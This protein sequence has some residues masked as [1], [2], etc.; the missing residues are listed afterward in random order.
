MATDRSGNPL[1]FCITTEALPDIPPMT[2]SEVAGTVSKA[3]DRYYKANTCYGCTDPGSKNFDFQ[4]NVDDDS[5]GEKSVNNFTFGGVFQTCQVDPDHSQ[6]NLCTSITQINPLTGGYSCPAGYTEVKLRSGT[7]SHVSYGTVCNQVC[8]HCG[9]FGWSKCCSCQ[10]VNVA[11]M[12]MARYKTFWC[13]ALSAVQSR[14]Y[15]FGGVFTSASANPVTDAA[16]CPN[17]F[18]PLVMGQDVTVC[19]STDYELGYAYSLRFAGFDSCEVGNPFAA[20]VSARGDPAKW[21]NQCIRGYSQHLVTIDDG[22]EINYCLQSG[23]LNGRSLMPIRL[24]PFSPPPQSKM[25]VTE[26]SVVGGVGGEVWLRGEGNTW[27]KQRVGATDGRSLLNLLETSG[28][29]SSR[30][31]GAK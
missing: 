28:N 3:I 5:C 14:G 15:L 11:Y 30:P 31:A 7:V 25:N 21:P 6:E 16:K 29:N 18:Y 17:H 10:S 27:S 9:L 1:H 23:A 4:A 13:A 8:R 2:V 26:A 19:V 22:C 24:P 12:S 20:P